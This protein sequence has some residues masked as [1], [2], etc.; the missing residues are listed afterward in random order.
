VVNIFAMTNM[1]PEIFMRQAL[2]LQALAHERRL[3]IVS[4]LFDREVAVG[5]IYSMLDL[6]QANVSQHLK[7]LKE[8]GIVTTRREGKQIFYRI[9]DLRV[10]D[11]LAAVRGLVGGNGAETFHLDKALPLVHDPVCLM[12]VSAPLSPFRAEY[13][14]QSYYFC[15]SGCMKQFEKDPKHYV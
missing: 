15:A 5:N 10:L 14:G 1:Y 6:P 8:Q 3:E 2:W 13:E 4:L 9:A 12:R 7:V 11:L